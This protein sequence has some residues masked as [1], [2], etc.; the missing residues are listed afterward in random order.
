M[1][2]KIL[3]L[4]IYCLSFTG[5]MINAVCVAHFATTVSHFTGILS[6]FSIRLGTLDY[7][8]M[9]SLIAL[10]LSFSGG[11]ILAGLIINKAE[12]DLKKRYGIILLVVGSVLALVNALTAHR[13]FLFLVYLAF[14]MGLQN[15]L[16]PR[17]HGVVVRTTHMSGNL[18]DFGVYLGYFIRNPY[19][20]VHLS[21]SLISF[22]NVVFF[23]A[24]GACGIGLFPFFGRYFFYFVALCY[25]GIAV[26]YFRIRSLY[27]RG[28]IF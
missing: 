16:L 10:F 18:T 12:F 19:D 11:G 26:F 2:S 13:R 1:Y 17:Y 5:G 20:P 23:V 8:N 4:W 28:Y 27:L 15:G 14:L 3:L 21:R 6:R 7:G 22:L 25:Y 24:G 9:G